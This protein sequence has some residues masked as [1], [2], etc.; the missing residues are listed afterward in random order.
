MN[1]L[2]YVYNNYMEL[3]TD[4]DLNIITTQAFYAQYFPLYRSVCL[5]THIVFTEHHIE[6]QLHNTF[7]T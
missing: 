1:V 5:Y 3:F 2:K 6:K 7:W 4:P